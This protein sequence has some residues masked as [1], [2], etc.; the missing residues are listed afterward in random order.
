ML[1]MI[2]TGTF[3]VLNLE[4]EQRK[5]NTEQIK[6]VSRV[7]WHMYCRSKWHARAYMHNYLVSKI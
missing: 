3:S 4:I 1:T 6:Q 2:L 5:M 7:E